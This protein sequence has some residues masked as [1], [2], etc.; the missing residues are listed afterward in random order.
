LQSA[1]GVTGP[2]TAVSGATSPATITIR[3]ANKALFYRVQ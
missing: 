2:W 3:T 1:A